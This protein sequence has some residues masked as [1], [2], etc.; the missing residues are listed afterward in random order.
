MAAGRFS[1]GR[2]LVTGQVALSLMLLVGAGLFL[3]TL[4][5]LLTTDLGFNRHNVLLVRADM[6]QTNVPKDAAPACVPGDR[7]ASARHPRRVVGLQFRD[8]AHRPRAVG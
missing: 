1:L 6:M 8:D 3:G 4:R 7:G 5:N 2:A